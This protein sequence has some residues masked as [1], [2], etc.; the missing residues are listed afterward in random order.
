MRQLA[1]LQ[2]VRDK[3]ILETI[4]QKF[5]IKRIS[6]RKRL[7]LVSKELEEQEEMVLYILTTPNQEFLDIDM[8]TPI[9]SV[10]IKN[11]HWKN[12]KITEVRQTKSSEYLLI[13]E[14]RKPPHGFKNIKISIDPK[15]VTFHLIDENHPQAEHVQVICQL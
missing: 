14:C 11:I 8:L 15:K 10:Q 1:S 12:L 5:R 13:F 9:S 2:T 3:R 6:W 7:V 4:L